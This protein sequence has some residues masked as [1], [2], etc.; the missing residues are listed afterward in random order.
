MASW[1]S[2]AWIGFGFIAE[3]Q[4]VNQSPDGIWLEVPAS[5][6]GTPATPLP[7]AFHA[8]RVNL[9]ALAEKLKQ[10]PDETFGLRAPSAPVPVFLPMA[11]GGF[12]QVSVERSRV[13][14]VRLALQYPDIHTFVFRGVADTALH[15][16]MTL[17]PST[18]QA[19]MRPPQDLSRVHPLHTSNGVFYITFLNHDRTDGADDFS[20][21]HTEPRT[22]RDDVPGIRG[23]TH[24]EDTSLGPH[25]PAIQALGQP[26]MSLGLQAGGTLR[27]FS[28]AVATTGEYYQARDLGNGDADVVS[29]IVAE[30]GNANVIFEAEV[31]VR[32]SLD[33]VVLFNDPATD[34]YAA[35]P[36]ACQFRDANPAV[37]DAALTNAGYD[38][39]FVFGSGGGNGCA[40]YVVCQHDKG[41]GAGLINTATVVVGGSSGLLVHEMG[42]QLGGRHTFSA[43][44]GS[45]G[46]PGEFNQPDA[47][48]PGSGS[49]VESYRGSCS[50]NNVDL[51]VIGGGMYYHTHTFDQIIDNITNNAMCGASIATGNNPPSVNAGADYT[52]PQGTPFTLVGSATDPDGDSLTYN[53]EQF[54]VAANPR[55]I[56]TDTGEGPIFRSMPPTTDPSRTFPNLADLLSNTVRKGEILPSTDRTL[57]F[58]LVARDNRGGGGGVSYDDNLLTVSG[59]PFFL[60]SPNGGEALAAGCTAPA[61]WVVGGGA[62]ANDVSL[63]FSNDSGQNFSPLVASTPN[64][65][66]A[67]FPAPWAATNTARLKAAALGNVFF[68]VSDNDVR[69]VSVPPTVHVNAAGGA[70][71]NQCHFTVNFTAKVVDDCGVNK[72]TVSV[73]PLKQSNNFTVG[74]VAFNA[75]QT[76]GTTVDVTGSVLVSGLT[77]SPAVLSI[78]VN[79]QDG[80]G[81]IGTDS[82]Q[83]Q[84]VD[85][86]PPTI[87]ESVSPDS[88]WPPNHKLQNI[89]AQV[90][91]ADNCPNVSYVLASI[92]SNEPD[93]GS[94]DGN[95]VGDIQGASL[96]TPDT[97][98]SLRSE[99]AGPKPGRIYSIKYTAT[100]GSGST[101]TSTPV[102]VVPHNK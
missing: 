52:I 45:C 59:P 35:G 60:T 92:T 102:V 85:N 91:V 65:G 21:D 97:S 90:V 41:R 28:L 51:S 37:L 39:G 55:N 17:D 53:W 77:G 40:W 73:Q 25:E 6:L 5:A 61:N 81:N 64:D 89:N 33:N 46:N 80:R 18:F 27:Q 63:L 29:S 66:S 36:T 38:I 15:G 57:S 72:N 75:V 30:V 67:P 9:D 94:G 8:F 13:M 11:D 20:L 79:G 74:P 99:R 96:G 54:D 84:V 19:A 23:A 3:A 58:R 32:M 87:S 88:L 70:V 2:L 49:T 95:T 48:E 16:R 22:P 83:V 14:S 98:F 50:P 62:V 7:R 76:N 24:E 100:D 82:V 34:P 12:K 1:A 31:A 69:V 78:K 86:T 42:H 68:D 47:Y 44:T 43:L 101:A 10:A 71:D 93:N 26:I 4:S 56:N